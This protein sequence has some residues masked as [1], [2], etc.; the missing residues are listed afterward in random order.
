MTSDTHPILDPTTTASVPPAVVLGGLVLITTLLVILWRWWRRHRQPK[1]A[2]LPVPLPAGAMP[3]QLPHADGQERH[4]RSGRI[5]LILS[6]TFAGNVGLRLLQQL[7]RCG[8]SG[9]VGSILLLEGDSG[10]RDAFLAQ[11]PP[12]FR[13]RIVAVRYPALTGGLANGSPSEVQDLVQ[14]WGP[15]VLEGADEIC[16]RHMDLHKGEEAALGLVFVSQGGQAIIGADAVK[17]ISRQF[18]RMKWF[19]FTALPVDQRLRAQVPTVLDLYRAQGVHGFVVSDN[20]GDPVANDFGMVA[21]IAGFA[22]AS[23][24][25]DAAVEQ[26][27]AWRLLFAQTPG[28]LVSINTYVRQ[29]PA[30]QHTPLPGTP[31]R[32]YVYRDSAVATIHA[33]LHEVTRSEYRSVPTVTLDG[34]PEM[35]SQFDILLT[36]IVPEDLKQVEDLVMVGQGL[37]GRAKRNYHLLFAP[38]TADVRQGRVVCPVVAVSIR[39]LRDEVAALR[40]LV[41][42]E[43]KPRPQEETAADQITAT[44]ILAAP[45]D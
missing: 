20:L 3:I 10:R 32:Y 27:N 41:A 14:L 29:I 16:M 33:C 1:V 8:M 4:D 26:N 12:L 35:T 21:T 19:G 18:R 5:M 2:P 34:M 24:H 17:H 7:D 6:G 37:T 42:P 13:D 31:E 39:A 44:H 38:I 45:H 22:A 43:T 15:S 23:E 9:T 30:Y 36:G 28:G 11:M 40:Q 25:A